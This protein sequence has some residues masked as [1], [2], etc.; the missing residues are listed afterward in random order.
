MSESVMNPG[1]AP[2]EL[3]SVRL[4]S[5]GLTREPPRP[6]AHREPGYQARYDF[7]TLFYDV[8]ATADGRA[9]LGIAPPLLNCEPQVR[10]AQFR[11]VPDGAPLQH[12]FLLSP[13]GALLRIDLR[14]EPLPRAISMQ[15]GEHAVT[16][17]VRRSNCAAFAGRRVIFTLSKDNP[18][19]WI[20]DWARFNVCVHGADAVIVYDNN[21][22][23][24]DAL[25]LRE[26]LAEVDGLKS[27]LVVDWR[28]PFG[29]GHGPNGEW[30]SNYCK[31]RALEHVRFRHCALASAVLNSDVDELVVSLGGGTVFER[32]AASGEPC[33]TYAGR[34]V[35]AVRPGLLGRLLRFV[36]RNRWQ[37]HHTDC[38]FL[39]A[40]APAYPNK[41]VADPR[42]CGEDGVWLTHSIEG[43]PGAAA[44][45][46]DSSKPTTRDIEF[47][48]C[49][50]ISTSWKY[51]RTRLRKIGRKV[52]YDR[53][54]ARA[55]T[56][57]FP[58]RHVSRG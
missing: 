55:L 22:S 36:R 52:R 32:L 12:M 54:L 30:D 25:Q 27:S 21:S 31:N 4:S 15:I 51:P 24:Y 40:N 48:H 44:A 39:E 6:A 43:L 56:L 41:W 16:I 29:P 18:L 33:L 58:K 11:R 53:D 3:S 13:F 37:P 28:F 8:F 20:Q 14:D 35:T 19:A 5:F 9:I 49:R 42:L 23:E 26:A 34:W 10:A 7:D 2:A 1:D 57:A 47:R 46:G 38:V 45:A 17:P 50:Q